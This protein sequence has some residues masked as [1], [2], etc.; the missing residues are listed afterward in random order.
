[1]E[2]SQLKK[3]ADFM[4]GNPASFENYKYYEIGTRIS[5]ILKIFIER[6]K[7]ANISEGKI[8]EFKIVYDGENGKGTHY[9]HF[10]IGNFIFT[11]SNRKDRLYTASW[12]AIRQYLQVLTAAGFIFEDLSKV[13]AE[14]A[15]NLFVRVNMNKLK[16]DHLNNF[17]LNLLSVFKDKDLSRDVRG[18]IF[19]SLL[20]SS[21]K[22]RNLLNND[23]YEYIK[24]RGTGNGRNKKVTE[25]IESSLSKTYDEIIDEAF[26]NWVNT[27][28]VS[29]FIDMSSTSFDSTSHNELE[30][31]KLHIIDEMKRRR[32][33]ARERLMQ[34]RGYA[35]NVSDFDIKHTNK[36]F[37]NLLEAAHI[38]PYA[39]IKNEIEF[40]LDKT[41]NMDEFRQREAK[42]KKLLDMID[43]PHN[44]LLIPFNIHKMFDKGYLYLD[45][46]FKFKIKNPADFENL[47]LILKDE[48]YEISKKAQHHLIKNYIELYMLNL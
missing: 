33:T 19:F 2:N 45:S 42:F 41:I 1:M 3:I 32:N 13:K 44:L 27:N 7:Y 21:M 23:T 24:M 20:V 26:V 38:F 25:S 5:Q 48:E 28:N 4:N 15:K 6:I 22:R 47:K 16:D 8:P 40:L 14:N 37:S 18:D 9:F 35:D 34:E 29:P 30:I 46:D 17:F 36:I 39:K 12:P 43:D 10:E 31:S 11:C